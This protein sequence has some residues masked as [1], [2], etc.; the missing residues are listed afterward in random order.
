LATRVTAPP[1]VVVTLV[2]DLLAVVNLPVAVRACRLA[3][4]DR[5]LLSDRLA[6]SGPP[7]C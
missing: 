3:F 5:S 4:W 6:I 1:L 2:R 7:A